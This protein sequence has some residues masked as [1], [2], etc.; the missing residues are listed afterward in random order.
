M[1]T[2]LLL[3][4]LVAGLFAG[5]AGKLLKEAEK[6]YNNYEFSAAARIYET[7]L[8]EHDDKAAML[9]LADCYRQMNQHALSEQWYARAINTPQAKPEDK[10]N[11]AG[12]LRENGK[13]SEA[14]KMYAD[15][16]AAVPGDASAM[17]QKKSC[18]SYN[19][20][21]RPDPFFDVS[22][23]PLGFSGSC[24][25]PARIGNDLLVC[26]ETPSTEK[27]LVNSS[28]TGNGFL[29]LYL[30]NNEKKATPLPGTV[31]SALHEGPASLSPLGNV[32]YFTR[33]EMREGKASKAS[34]RDNHLEICTADLMNGEWTNVKSLSF[35]SPDYSCGHPA[36]SGNGTRLYFISDMP[37]G[38]GGTD[39]YYSDFVNGTWSKPVNAGEGIN[40]KGDEMFPT[41]RQI[42][43]GTDELYFSTEGLVG[44]GGLDIYYC[45]VNSGNFSACKRMPFPFN[46]NNDDFGII[47]DAKGKSGYFS[48]NRGSENGTDRIYSFRR[49]D[50]A[51]FVDLVIV[52]KET[53]A[54][55]PLTEV[56]VLNGKDKSVNKTQTAE[57]GHLVFPADSL[58]NYGFTLRCSNY[59]CGFSSVTTGGF[60][61]SLSDT[62]HFTIEIE[63][64]V[65]NKPIRL[66][67]IY[68]DYNKWNI[69]PDAAIEL[70]KLV[71][72]MNDNPKIRIELSSHTDCRGGDNFNMKLSQKRAQSAVDYIVSKGISRDRI[73]AKGYGESV[74]LN[75]CV[76]GVKCNEDEYQLNRRTEFKVVQILQ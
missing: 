31:N 69:R 49:K 61:G 14:E 38:Y 58:T 73:Y 23:F 68:Y 41:I 46:S 55:V 39:I 45:R 71:K 43:P 21:L 6:H 25:S 32:L 5:C 3:I 19:E 56:E 22:E 11:Y 48:S 40:T 33:S 17:N 20:L 53:K 34:D 27:D 28:W 1:K 72:L 4:V 67:N 42:V 37:G 16:L 13:C 47:F 2:K 10:L 50:P 12:V 44:A 75:K 26:A 54:P 51:F 24:F 63:K 65:I 64:I 9:H 18:E 62:T 35:N 15:Y 30:V 8:K 70:D 76:N 66:D 60:R 36:L 52:D 59:F 29:D 57:N 74:P 7:Y